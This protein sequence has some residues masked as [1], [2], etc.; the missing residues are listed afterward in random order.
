MIE[1]GQGG[2]FPYVEMAKLLEHRLGR[3]EEALKLTRKAVLLCGPDQDEWMDALQKRMLRLY[4][5]C[6]K[7]GLAR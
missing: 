3:P 1:Q 7:R 2:L 6:E 5:K 4:R